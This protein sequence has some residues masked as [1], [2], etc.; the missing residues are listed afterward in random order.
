MSVSD[1]STLVNKPNAV[2][3][4][5]DKQVPFLSGYKEVADLVEPVLDVKVEVAVEDEVELGGS[6][7]KSAEDGFVLERL[8]GVEVVI[9]RAEVMDR[10][11]QLRVGGGR[12]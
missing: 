6:A 11:I 4:Y 10:L 8:Q 1:S 7:R 2:D 5:I 3:A 9:V 12:T